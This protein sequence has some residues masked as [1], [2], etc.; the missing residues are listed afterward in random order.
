MLTE[1]GIE[2]RWTKKK[3]V[4][5][6]NPRHDLTLLATALKTFFIFAEEGAEPIFDVYVHFA[7]RVTVAHAPLL[8]RDRM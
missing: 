6:N 2:K 8:N 3:V 5:G 4:K 1:A 7:H